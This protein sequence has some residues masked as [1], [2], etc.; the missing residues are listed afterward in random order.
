MPIVFCSYC[1]LDTVFSVY[2]YGALPMAVFPPVASVFLLVFT[3]LLIMWLIYA[4]PKFLSSEMGH[5]FI[6][7]CA[8]VAYAI[9]WWVCAF[10]WLQYLLQ[11]C[12]PSG[13]IETLSEETSTLTSQT[14]TTT[15]V[16]TSTGTT[17]STD[18]SLISETTKISKTDS[19]LLSSSSSDSTSTETTTQ[20][21]S[22]PF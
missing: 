14:F 9:L 6:S 3:T 12:L 16:V 1:N 4:I 22:G 2:V 21:T 13:R 18:T 5:R 20:E 11:D 17:T 8:Q 10:G 19:T 15:T 7:F